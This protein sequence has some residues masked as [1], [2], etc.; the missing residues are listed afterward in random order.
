[1]DDAPHRLALIELLE[2]DGR[3]RQAIEVRRWPVTIGRAFDN[4]VV[5]DDAHV[6]PL[7]ARIVQD[8]GGA[9]QLEVAQG[10]L[11]AVRA[12]AATVGA[13]QQGPLPRGA[14]Q[15]GASPLRVRWPGEALKPE[16]VLAAGGAWWWLALLAALLLALE[17]GEV[18]VGLDPG[19]R[20]T[21]WLFPAL[22]VAGAVV[23]WAGLWG[24][25]SK[26]FQHRFAFLPHLSI[27]LR[28]LLAIGVLD[29][30]LPLLG[31]ALSWPGLVASGG[32]LTGLLGLGMLF[33]HARLVL[34]AHRRAAG[35]TLASVWVLGTGAGAINLHQSS[36]RWF[37][38][39]YMHQLAPPTLRLAPTVPVASFVQEA[40]ALKAKLAQSVRSDAKDDAVS[41]EP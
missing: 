26:I 23:V 7:H 3:V 41:D 39:L 8:A 32:L 25:A 24:L 21:A 31:F 37:G 6:A 4:D 29:L 5:L 17:L 22:A 28:W 10:V 36:D 35:L 9:L 19:A 2:R 40:A 30:L 11:N 12:G 13:G 34:P 20:V 27:A 15:I 38:P 18:L 33:Q 14:W 16:R 1:M